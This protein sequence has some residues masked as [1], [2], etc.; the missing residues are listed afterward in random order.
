MP[1]YYFR[2]LLRLLTWPTLVI[3][4]SFTSIIW[5]TQALRFIDFIINRGLSVRDFLYLT[6]L[7]LPSL[8][9]IILPVA[10]FVAVLFTYSRLG[11]DN[12]LVVMKAA[13]LSP[14]QL[15]RP[16]LAMALLVTVLCY[17][18]TLYLM[19]LTKRQFKDMQ[20]FLRDNYA[21]VLL[22]EEVF[23]TPV[24]GM[25]VFVRQRDGEGTLRGI[26][27]HDSRTAGQEITMMAEEAKLVQTPSGPRFYLKNG[28]RQEMRDGRLSWLNFDAYQ[29]DISFYTKASA[30]R[31]RGD[32]ELFLPELLH[33][34]EMDP[35]RALRLKIEAH[36]RLT[37]PACTLG[38]AM[39]AAA[40]L[41]R[42]QYNRRGQ[43]K[44][45]L[46]ACV[47]ATGLVLGFSG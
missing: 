11:G 4:V 41:L 45:V 3:V 47:G 27:V 43:W 37:W 32:E 1:R 26:L 6:S 12:E 19:P 28:M 18:V 23:N 36:R 29:L 39:F 33:P 17:T 24:D 16:V 5:L 22:Q 2:Y 9:M 20:A 13:G 10:L 7:L 46:G 30:N 31:D 44:Y 42:G 40:M 25:T 14:R 34:E 15:A 35:A 38:L 21:S 8:M